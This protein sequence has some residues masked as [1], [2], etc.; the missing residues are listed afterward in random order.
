MNTWGLQAPAEGGAGENDRPTPLTN[1]PAQPSS[2]LEGAKL[3]Q[4]QSRL[5]SA[6][7]RVRMRHKAPSPR[8]VAS[9]VDQECA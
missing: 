3:A 9:A 4:P 2:F 8:E 1:S 6:V 7:K 5:R